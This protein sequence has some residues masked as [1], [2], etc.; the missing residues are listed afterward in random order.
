MTSK[1][2]LQN[3]D[4]ALALTEDMKQKM[5]E[6]YDRE[7]SVVPN[8][9]DLER[10]NISSGGKK[11]GSAKTLIFVGRLHPVKGVRYLIEAMAIVYQEMPDVKL[12]IVGDGVERSKLE[13]LA[14]KR[15]LNGCIQFV[16]QLPQE[17]I[18]PVM[19]Q[20]DVFVLSSL[21]EVGIVNLEARLRDCP[22]SQRT[23][24]GFLT[25]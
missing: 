25:L 19:H 3:A 24:E 8:G 1:L 4:A 15:N 14:E 9:I 18:P 10:F 17:R 21:S 20:A 22:S 23:L 2:I 5:Q 6:I 16:G 13:E 11:R 12:V 7:I